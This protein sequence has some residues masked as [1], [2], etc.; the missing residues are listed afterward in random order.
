VK[1]TRITVFAGG[2]GLAA[3]LAASVDAALPPQ[4]DRWNEFA[5]IVG[6]SAIPAKL[7]VRNPADRIERMADGS[8]RVQGGNCHLIVK[9][10]RRNP[11]GPQ[12]QPMVGASTVS[13]ASVGDPV[14]Q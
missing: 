2:L 11:T 12:G 8:Y 9:L 7:G 6:D 1:I 5:A 3:V 4:Y 14:C 13:V 10:A